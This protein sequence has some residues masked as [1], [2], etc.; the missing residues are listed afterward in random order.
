M[1]KRFGVVFEYSMAWLLPIAG[2]SFVIAWLK[3]RKLSKLPD[4]SKGMALFISGLRF[5]VIFT[6]LALLLNPAFSWVEKTKEK[7]LLVL[8]QDNSASLIKT[9]DSLYYR[10][11]YKASLEKMSKALKS[12][13]DIVPLTFGASIRRNDEYDFSE[14]YTNISAVFDYTDQHFIVR[15][16]AAMILFSDGIY[17]TGVNPK[18]KTPDFPVYTV[19][20]GDTVAYPDVYI[21]NVETDKFNFVNTIFPIKVEVGAI[22]QKGSQVKCSLKQND[23]VIARQILTIGQD[24]FF[25]EVSFEVEAPKKGI[26]RYSV[27]L[28]ND[29]VERTYENNRI[30]TWMNIIDNSAKVAIYT[31]VP[32]PDI[33]AIKNAVGVSGI[34]R[35]KLYRWEE[36]LDSLNANLVILH[37][38]DPHST[39]YQQLMQ[40][41]NRRKLSVWYILTTPECIAGFSKLQN[42]YT[43]DI[44]ADK[45]EYASLQINEQFS[46]FEF[47]ETEK[48]AY[49]D[50]PPIIVPFGEINTGAGKILFSQKIKNTPTSNG[51]LGFYDLNG[52]KISYFWGE[53]LWKWRLYSYQE[54]GNHEPFNTLINK[55]VGYL[56]T[57]QGAERLVDDIEPLYEESEEI[58]IN[59]ELYNDSYELINTPDLKMELNIG[60]KT[61]NYLF[62]RNGEKYR[63]TLG[64]LQAGEY[65]F[66]L[67]TDLK[68]E[69]FTKKGIFYVKS[70]NPELN[71]LVADLSLLKEIAR[72]TGGESVSVRD[73]A[74]L[75]NELNSNDRYI[76]EY[77]SETGFSDLSEIKILGLIIL[78]LLCM[79]WFL[80]KFFAG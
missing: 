51:I 69:R 60:G 61:Y 39:G 7:P 27:E 11:E 28:E 55:I 56:T 38:P 78:L 80:L 50:Y 71:R 57:R 30:E 42:L 4:I 43:S 10:N 54:N 12:K 65:N 35:C 76:S 24:Y 49:K 40:E 64:N 16:P 17:N 48:A 19:A 23:Q 37:N 6:L 72:H 70:H 58:V 68:G 47:S 77:K 66:R 52:Q 14:Q 74:R 5:I 41:I 18:Y 34:Y 8:A 31:T 75:T 1:L 25:Q 9:K 22:K 26:F 53:G 2:L 21:R 15:R 20:L 45:T 73:M 33:A 32:H 13:F 62:N 44:S 29:R 36:P 46:Y 79:E 63:M 3:F 67:S 59:V